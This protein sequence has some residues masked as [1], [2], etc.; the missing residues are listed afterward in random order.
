MSE[1][2]SLLLVSFGGPE[3]REDVMPFLRNVLKG[4]NV[5]E[6]RMEEV[7][8]HYYMFNGVSPINEQNKRLIRAIENDFAENG[9]KLPV[10]W[11]NRNWHPM[12]QDTLE[13]MKSDGVKRSL[14]FF[15]SG[16]SCYS[17]CRQY[18]ENIIEAR[19]AIGPDAPE[20]DKLRVFFN[21]PKFIETCAVRLK[22]A[23]K[24]TVSNWDQAVVLFTA[25]SIPDSMA[26]GCN[27]VKQLEEASR[28]VA[29]SSGATNWKLVY[30]SRSGRPSQPWLEPDVCDYIEEVAEQGIKEV[31]IMP[32]GFVS[33]H[34]EVIFDLD[35]EARE[36]CEKVGIKLT[37]AG[38]AGTH[39]LFVEMIRELVLERMNKTERPALGSLGPSHDVCPENCCLRACRPE[40][41]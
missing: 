7:A 10:Y 2:E 35:V 29:E 26:V 39:P 12:L 22:Q 13:Q 6:A 16:F 1:Y 40:A 30:Q 34:M 5:P 18:R 25:H 24:E 9:I 4:R 14:A 23:I 28:L 31:V 19:N 21:H 37:R 33:D 20:V 41:T 32:I 15:T 17:G 3:K 8:Q 27:Y 38:T 36:T 11:G